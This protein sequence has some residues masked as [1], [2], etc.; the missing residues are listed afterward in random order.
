MADAFI[1]P[2][3]SDAALALLHYLARLDRWPA[4]FHKITHQQFSTLKRRVP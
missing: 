2:N 4:P 1:S 3:D